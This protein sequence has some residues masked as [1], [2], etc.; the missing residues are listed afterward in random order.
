MTEILEAVN[1]ASGAWLGMMWAVLWQSALLVGV[2]A[3]AALALRRSS[4][5][6]RYWL[7]QIVAVKL[8]LMPLWTC[9]V[10]LPW[11]L[12]PPV[13]LVSLAAQPVASAAMLPQAVTAAPSPDLPTEPAGAT[14]PAPASV[15]WSLGQ[16]AWPSWVLLAWSAMVAW[17]VARLAMQRVRLGRLLRRATPADAELAYLVGRLAERLGLRRAPA[18]VLADPDC[19]IFVCGLWR[20]TLVLPRGL[21]DSLSAA[22]LRQAL[23][24]ELAHVHRRDL[25]WG[26]PVEIARVVY[27]FNPLVHWVGFRLRLERELACDQLAMALDGR[28]P[29]DYVETLIQ[30][31]C[32]AAATRMPKTPA[33]MAARFDGHAAPPCGEGPRNAGSE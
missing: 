3:L 9:A 28:S 16:V 23:L 25:L 19:A 7:W 6:V 20:P 29:A 5:A 11:P 32:R 21:S 10:S 15:R 12:E 1:G 27:F 33:A 22:Q 8:L 4:P 24:H 14:G 2:V 17:Q 26:W 13:P 30:V 31:V 18:V